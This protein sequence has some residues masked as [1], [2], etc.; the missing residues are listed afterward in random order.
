VAILIQGAALLLEHV[1]ERGHRQVVV[2]VETLSAACVE[3][4]PEVA[5]PDLLRL[6]GRR[7]GEGVE[8]L[9]LEVSWV[10]PNPESTASSE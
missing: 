10:V 7:E 6:C 2:G 5:D 3:L 8:A 1:V 4:R 9:R